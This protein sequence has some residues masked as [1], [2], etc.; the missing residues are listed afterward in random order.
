MPS[1]GA[2][3]QAHS[4]RRPAF[5]QEKLSGGM[6]GE[7][8][9][10]DM[11]TVTCPPPNAGSHAAVSLSWAS[12]SSGGVAENLTDVVLVRLMHALQTGYCCSWLTSACSKYV[13][14]DG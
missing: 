1:P 8:A 3:G 5:L 4:S 10:G 11:A 9:V 6:R 14:S 2:S 13:A 7:A 12:R